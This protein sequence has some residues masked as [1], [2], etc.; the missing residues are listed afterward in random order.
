[1]TCRA[2]SCQAQQERVTESR[3]M[4]WLHAGL[5][6]ERVAFF[7]HQRDPCLRLRPPRSC[8][9]ESSRVES[10]SHPSVPFRHVGS[11][12]TAQSQV[13]TARQHQKRYGKLHQSKFSRRRCGR[14]R[15][16]CPHTLPLLC[17]PAPTTPIISSHLLCSVG[18]PIH[19]TP[20][21]TLP[22]PC[23]HF[24]QFSAVF[25]T[26]FGMRLTVLRPLF[27]LLFVATHFYLFRGCARSSVRSL[28]PTTATIQGCI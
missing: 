4:P 28:N 8:R 19:F 6:R 2:P 24:T 5:M 20:P 18:T 21:C 25:R 11:N 14:N 23:L 16:A 12:A 9:V 1:M 7:P 17:T 22:A 10:E 13:A 3:C 26:N 27:C 15:G